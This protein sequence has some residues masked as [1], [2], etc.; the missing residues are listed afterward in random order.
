[1]KKLLLTLLFFPSILMSQDFPTIS[2]SGNL[3]DSINFYSSFDA[4]N[5]GE[6]YVDREKEIKRGLFK[7]NEWYETHPE[8]EEDFD[9]PP[10]WCYEYFEY[11][12]RYGRLT[13]KQ[14]LNHDCDC[15]YNG[16]CP[17]FDTYASSTLIDE[18]DK[19]N[20]SSENITDMDPRTAWVEGEEGYGI[21]EYIEFNGYNSI[22]SG[23]Q[24][25]ILNGFQKS[26]NLWKNNSRVKTFK[27]YA[28]NIPICFLEL[29]DIMGYQVINLQPLID[30]GDISIIRLEIYDV[31][32][33]EK[34]KDVCISDIFISCAG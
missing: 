26:I 23:T 3:S 8:L 2:T 13:V 6:K 21:G 25:V 28:D 18:K 19:Y 11:I 15:V 4:Y 31:Y 22:W 17:V 14:F 9:G 34:W 16:N 33:G 20:Y 1:M 10:D 32:K 7:L 29:E 24:I 27:V 30:V 12:R 5:S